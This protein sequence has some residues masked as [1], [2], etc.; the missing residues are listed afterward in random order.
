MDT[1]VAG[2]AAPRAVTASPIERWAPVAGLLSVALFVA[3][4]IVAV[5]AIDTGN[6]KL[7]SISQ[8]FSTDDY[9]TASVVTMLLVF[10]SALCFLW[11]L[12]DLAASAR[13]I[14]PGML[15]SL[16]PIG[17]V[18]FITGTVAGATAFVA[19]LYS[20]NHSEL[21]G[22]DAKTTAT[23]YILLT[24]LAFALVALGAVGGALMMGSAATVAYRGGFLP[25]WA[26]ILVVLGA[27][28]VAVGTFIALVPFLL[29]FLWMLAASLRRTL[30]VSR[31]VLNPR[32]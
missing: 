19:P 21:A 23:S 10:L 3:A 14:S 20:I 11:F 2:A 9:R 4:V 13:A 5:T 1:A 32:M 7:S 18:V 28:V 31:G 29:G 17:G 30:L 8:H 6:D 24:S 25:R 16:V 26:V 22:A 12:A 27:V 15:A